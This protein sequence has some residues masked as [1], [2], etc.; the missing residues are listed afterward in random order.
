MAAEPSGFYR[1]R[2]LT[3][4]CKWLTITGQVSVMDTNLRSTICAG[5]KRART[6]GTS[7]SSVIVAVGLAR[8]V[9]L[10]GVLVIVGIL[11]K[12]NRVMV[13]TPPKQFVGQTAWQH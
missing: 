6:S 10:L 2:R 1:G 13:L 12:R 5:V 3:E 8:S 7:T 4:S 11:L 9:G